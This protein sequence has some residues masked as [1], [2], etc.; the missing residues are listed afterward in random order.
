MRSSSG[1]TNLINVAKSGLLNAVVLDNLTKDT[2]VTATNNKDLLGV[3]VGVEGK[4]GNHL[5]VGELI[6]LGALDDIV[7]DEDVAIVSGLE[8]E[9]ILVLALLVMQDLLDLEGHG[10][11]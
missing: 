6:A 1:C 7:E 2:T 11:A 3:G 4:V 8:D 9:H 10:L 5:L